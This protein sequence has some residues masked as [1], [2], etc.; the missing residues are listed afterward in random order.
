[1]Y[2]TAKTPCF[3]VRNAPKETAEAKKINYVSGRSGPVPEDCGQEPQVSFRS[4]FLCVSL[5]LL[6]AGDGMIFASHRSPCRNA[7]SKQVNPPQSPT[8]ASGR[9]RTTS[10][11]IRSLR[12]NSRGY[13]T[14][15]TTSPASDGSGRATASPTSTA[16]ASASATKT[17]W[18]ESASSRFRRLGPTFGSA[19]SKTAT[20]RRPAATRAP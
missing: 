16:T 18:S 1:M 9:R 4:V 19:L 3:P 17:R 11:P 8:A 7:K 14:S 10:S 5:P 13:A 15:P 2:C 20:F 6:N 12:P